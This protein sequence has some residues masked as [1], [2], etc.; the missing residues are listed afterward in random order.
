[1]CRHTF[2]LQAILKLKH[3]GIIND[4]HLQYNRA[5]HSGDRDTIGLKA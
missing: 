2:L 5:I 4:V 3:G 1:M